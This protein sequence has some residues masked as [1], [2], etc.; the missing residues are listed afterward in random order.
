MNMIR[1][2]ATFAMAL[3][4]LS[5]CGAQKPMLASNAY[6]VSVGSTVAERDIDECIACAQAGSEAGQTNKENQKDTPIADAPTSSLAGVSA[7]GIV[8]A[9]DGAVP[10]FAQEMLRA[11][12]LPN[13]AKLIEGGAFSYDVEPV[14]PSETAPGFASLITGA[15]PRVTGISGNR[16]PRAPREQF[17]VLESV[18]GFA[19]APLRAEPIWAAARRAGKKSVVAHIPPFAG[20]LAQDIVRFSGYALTAGPDGIVTKNTAQATMSGEWH[21]SPSSAAPAIEIAFSI[22]ESNFFGLIVDDPGDERVGYDTLLL[23]NARDGDAIAAKLKPAPSGRGAKL[24]W[25]D[26]VTIK[27][28]GDQ[29]AKSYFRLFDLNPDGSDFFLYYTPPARDLPLT[30]N[31]EVAATAP[32]RTFVGGGAAS[33]YQNGAFGR[34][35]PDGGSGG[36]EARY[37]ETV[38][39]AQ[40]QLTDTHLWAIENLPWDLFLAYTPFPDEAE[41]LWRGHLERSISSYRHDLAGR[42]RPWLEWVYQSS[43]ESLG[44]LMSRRPP[45]ALF[46]LISDHGLSGVDKLVALNR[47]LRGA[48]LLVL[49]SEGRVDLSRTK[50]IYPPINNGYLLINSKD[51]KGGIVS[52]HERAELI[53]QTRA[54]LLGLRDGEQPIV[55]AVHD[56]DTDGAALGVGGEVGGDIYVELAPGYDF[57]SRIGVGKMVSQTKAYG[58]HVAGPAQPD[59][60]TLMIFNGPGVKAG[61]KLKNVRIIDFAPTLARMLNLPKPKDATGRVLW[62]AMIDERKP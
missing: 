15:P 30:I 36:A 8:F 11:G 21:N 19:E 46:A 24:F 56:A 20:E 26:P 59:M 7:G 42:I 28:A 18:A 23:A 57:D 29:E 50:V 4:A 10:A 31:S 58:N 53:R 35:I 14:F 5:A 34:T 52:A 60:R 49:D 16:V 6:L 33:L 2:I 27:T 48:G 37:L 3:L 32:V 40:R 38:E 41:H 39:F 13:L 55:R 9:W 47:A 12:K 17:T 51:R 1:Q 54:L 22:K 62:E 61:Q 25:S 43:D 44:R 45:D